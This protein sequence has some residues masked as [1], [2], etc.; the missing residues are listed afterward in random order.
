MD[1]KGSHLSET[2]QGA[3]LQA[4]SKALDREA[5]VLTRHPGLLWQQLYNRLQWEDEAVQY[6]APQ[7]NRL[8]TQGAKPWLRLDIPHSESPMLSSTLEGHYYCISNCL[9]S[10]NNRWIAS[11]DPESFSVWEASTGL[12]LWAHKRLPGDDEYVSCGFLDGGRLV[13]SANVRMKVN[14]W[15]TITGR[16]VRSLALQPN[17][18]FGLDCVFFSPDESYFISTGMEGCV[19]IWDASNGTLINKF[20]GHGFGVYHCTISPDGLRIASTG[21]DQTIRVWEVSTG[22]QLHILEGHTG[23]VN[24]CRFSPDGSQIVSASYDKTLRLW[25]ML[26]GQLLQCLE[27]HTANVIDGSFSPDGRWIVS[28]SADRSLCLWDIGRRQSRVKLEGHAD[29]VTRCAFSPDGKWIISGSADKTLKLWKPILT[30]M[31]IPQDR[32][33]YHS[34][35]QEQTVPSADRI[36]GLH[37][38]RKIAYNPDLFKASRHDD[39]IYDCKFSPDGKRFA[40][41]SKDGKVSVIDLENDVSLG[42]IPEY[43]EKLRACCFSPDSKRIVI[44][45]QDDHFQVFDL[46]RFEAVCILEGYK[47]GIDSYDFSPN[48][49]WIVSGCYDRKV[50]IWNA[51]NGRLLH[52][53]EGHTAQVYA[54]RFLPD[55]T[56][57]VSASWDHYLRIWDTY[58]GQSIMSLDGKTIWLQRCAI[59]PDSRLIVAGGA[60]ELLVWDAQ[61]GKQISQQQFK[62]GLVRA[63]EFLPDGN[64]IVSI[65]DNRT[66]WVSD[67]QNGQGR[68]WIPL[69]SNATAMAV[70]PYLPYL[71]CGDDTGSLYGITLFDFIQGSQIVTVYEKGDR[72]IINCPACRQEQAVSP[73]Q[74]GN[75]LTCPTP[76]CGLRMRLNPFTIQ[77]RAKTMPPLGWSKK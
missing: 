49:Q 30:E 27:G 73:Q 41:L 71:V 16:L 42:S 7:L 35:P 56:R 4:F 75:E 50:R 68:G 17:V 74:L 52:I 38:G 25:D 54:C 28:A 20:S 61:T 53:L 44:A 63:C 36:F 29:A 59:S 70:H 60:H 64:S 66:L 9:F 57:F 62:L 43:K 32:S 23:L 3:V 19:R 34:S 5:H 67:P 18:P 39:W 33:P 10:Q 2:E 15:E 69:P 47:G 72:L 8:R 22:R 46:D 40:S 51:I 55:G 45:D 24:T 76:G 77:P 12:Q 6:L 31:A 37:R 65:S 26:S 48:G 14:I 1:E 21:Q 11:C 13:F 58:S